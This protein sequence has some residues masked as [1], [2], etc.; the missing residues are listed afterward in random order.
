MRP[1]LDGID[2]RRGLLLGRQLRYIFR[3]FWHSPELR[4][5]APARGPGSGPTFGTH[6]VTPE[7]IS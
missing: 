4:E 1:A 2:F 7:S 6:A 5:R 3:I